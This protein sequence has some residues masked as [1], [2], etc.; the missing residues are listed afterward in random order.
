MGGSQLQTLA[1]CVRLRCGRTV[2]ALNLE[3]EQSMRETTITYVSS[4]LEVMR[5]TKNSN[6]QHF[7]QEFRYNFLAL[8]Q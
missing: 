6:Q 3:I 8:G 2:D 5:P 7:V 1:N 4:R